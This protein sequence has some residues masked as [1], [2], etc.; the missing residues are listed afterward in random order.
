MELHIF[1]KGLILG[2]SIAA[3]VGPMGL[4]CIRRTLLN[5]MTTGF[6]SGLGTATA[7]ALYGCIA[8]FSLTVV[9]TFLFDHQE[10][11]RLT[12]GLLLLYLGFTT[13]ISK[14]A[15]VIDNS[16]STCILRSYTSAF[17]L[18]LTNP[19]TIMVFA[20]IFAGLGLGSPRQDLSL[21]VLL[22][23]GV[24]SGSSIWWLILSGTTAMLRARLNQAWV[25]WINWLSGMIIA[26]FGLLSLLTLF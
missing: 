4:L 6:I 8:A 15:P 2:F 11:L 26:A 20:A 24:F 16:D 13:F 18:T 17:F 3:P 9:S 12:G 21:S 1:I 23:A 10:L 14:P 22:V 25:K 7:D 5:G 19:L